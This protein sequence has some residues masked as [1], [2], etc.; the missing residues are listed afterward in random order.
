MLVP[1]YGF[2]D[3]D[4]LGLVILVQSDDKVSAI[5]KSLVEAATPRVAP[6]AAPVVYHAGRA[7]D[8]LITVREAGIQPLDRV[9]VR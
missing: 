9:D 1:L 3:G 5:A 4:T 2:L 7:L 8:P 6:P